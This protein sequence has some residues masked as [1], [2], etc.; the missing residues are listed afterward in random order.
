MPTPTFSPICL[1]TSTF[2]REID[3]A[4]AFDLMDHA[5]ARGV[6]V[7]DT[8]ALYAN[9]E[10]ERIVGAWLAAREQPPL[11]PAIATKIYPPYSP[12]AIASA[13]TASLDRLGRPSIDL[14][15]LH[16][17]DE[18]VDDPAGLAALDQ[19]VRAGRVGS[20]GASNFSASQLATALKRQSAHRL[21]PFTVLQNNHNLAV[22]NI[23]AKL[24]QLCAC[25]AITI[26][27]YSPLGAGF[28][29][30][31][32][33]HGVASDSRFA[34]SPSHCDVYFNPQAQTRLD[35]LE[36]VASRTGETPVRLALSWALHQPGIDSVLV[37]GR[38]PGHLDQAFDALAYTDQAVLDALDNA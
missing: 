14:L 2:G 36:S 34:L 5:L 8:A 29:T 11:N 32:H 28:L 26:V 4:A 20:L 31:K 15:Y 6:T 21:T 19:E 22:R 37:G 9:G 30:G 27:T 35:H 3:R 18:T 17:W 12:A 24:R 1:G 10:S 25:H 23:D 38:H 33:R 7:F 13:V 16:K